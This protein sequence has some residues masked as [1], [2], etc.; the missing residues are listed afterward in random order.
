MSD[1]RRPMF[2]ECRACGERWKIATVPAGALAVAR[3]MKTALCPNC[4]TRKDIWI[5]DTH[6]P[7]A[8][9]EARAGKVPT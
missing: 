8:V 6:G 9:T 5:C 7:E 4:M 3:A 1:E 2:A